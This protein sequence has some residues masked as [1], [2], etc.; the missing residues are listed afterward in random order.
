[1]ARVDWFSPDSNEP[2]FA[3][4]VSQMDTWQEAMADGVIDAQE[5]QD[6][7]DLVTRLLGELQP[8]LSDELHEEVTRVLFE[9]A[10]FYGMVQ[11]SQAAA[12]EEGEL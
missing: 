9:L 11:V 2:L 8:K 1:M 5:L 7:A 12:S 3:Q 6:Q 10:V 4:Y